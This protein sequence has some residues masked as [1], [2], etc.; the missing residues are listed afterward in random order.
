MKKIQYWFSFFNASNFY[1]MKKSL[2]LTITLL[3]CSALLSAQQLASIKEFSK[4][5]K[6]YPFTDPNP[7]PTKSSIYP[8]FRFDGFTD[9]P[10]EQKWKVVEME[11]QFIK[12]VIL[13]EVGGK[14]WG[15]WEKSTG[16]PFLYSNEVIK[17]RD[18]AMRGPYTS[19][20]IELNYGIFGHTPNCATPV[21]YKTEKKSDGS[22]S[23]YIGTFDKLTQTY[24]TIEVNLPADKAY[25]TTRSTWH[26]GNPL[27]QP[28]YHWMNAA[29]PATGGL[30]F[31][32]PGLSHIGHYG[33]YSTWKTNPDN[34]KD[35]SFY[36][37]NDFGTYKSYHVLGRYTDF[38]GTFY[39]TKNFGM[40]HYAL[41]DEKP[42]K[43]IWIWGLSRQGMIWEKLLTD[44]DGQYVEVQSGRLFNQAAPRSE[45]TPFKN[46]GFAPYSTDEWTEYWFP[47]KGT[48]GMVKA[49]PYGSLN[50][51]AEGGFLKW[52]F[53]PLQDF[54]ETIVVTDGVKIISDK[55]VLFKTL[56]PYRDS[57]KWSGDIK[58]ISLTMGEKMLYRADP[59]TE[60][61][62]RPLDLPSDFKWDTPHALYI[63]G[64]DAAQS[65]RY[66]KAENKFVECLQKD[67]YYSPALAEMAFLQL[68]KMDYGSARKSALKALSI[69]TYDP[70]A[71][72]AL[73]L[74]SVATQSITD[75]KDAFGIASAS[76]QF[77]SA[78]HTELAKLYCRE[79]QL[80]L[81][82]AYAQKAIDA[83]PKNLE[84]LQVMAII[85]RQQGQKE[86]A[87][88][89]LDRI[90]QI[91]PLSHF[92]DSE[93]FISNTLAAADFVGAIQQEMKEEI[94]LDLANTYQNVNRPADALAV[95]KQAPQ[96]AEVLYWQAYLLSEL[97]DS[98]SSEMLSKADLENPLFVF[99]YRTL[100]GKVFDWA[101]QH[102]PSWKP[103]YFLGL[104]HWN[105]GNLHIAKKLFQ[106][107][108]NPIFAPFHAAKAA[109]IKDEA[110]QVLIQ[111]VP[112]DKS[113]SE[114]REQLTK[115]Y[116]SIGEAERSL[117]QAVQLDKDEWLYRKLLTSH[118]VSI[119]ESKRALATVLDYH[120]RFP[121]NDYAA[122]LTA[123]CQMLNGQYQ[124]S[125][126][127]LV[128][129]NFLPNEGAREGRQLYNE[130]LLMMAFDNLKKAKYL[131][132]LKNIEKAREWPENLGVGKPYDS[133]LDERFENF[134]QA[135]CLEKMK[136][137]TE[138]DK[139]YYSLSTEKTDMKTVGLLINALS[140]KKQGT[141]EKGLTLLQQWK[142]QASD[143]ALPD[144]CIEN[145]TGKGKASE[146]PTVNDQTRLLKE[147]LE[148]LK[149]E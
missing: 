56:Q 75:A 117:V 84:A 141:P 67:P 29:M 125:H 2:F 16:Q 55:K 31:I 85:Y 100:A 108:G 147:L 13:P 59:S 145:F 91:N 122:F 19:G 28:Y 87:V 94:F 33:Q 37:Q 124:E 78:A 81:A 44:A 58:K 42:G 39:H 30:E 118:Y 82:V 24:W 142:D 97:H 106:Q 69:D 32:Y 137:K 128:S 134:L 15:A 76:V 50:L 4:T 68:R 52:Y 43:K 114:L 83:N 126:N 135:V 7:V 89:V 105:S 17:F 113:K 61:L 102:S 36:E 74:A 112:L 65:K 62:A 140:L 38:Y 98:S 9:R 116:L 144:W 27:G 86:K 18:V 26:N 99:P 10:V 149:G 25:F 92:V 51:K 12:L 93:K 133:E 110:E 73:G 96:Q 1:F 139:I 138:A 54:D 72:F 71:N 107:C 80:G 21:D 123:K 88:Q 49:N 109:L 23:C 14:V 131:D 79:A 64:K 120:K 129:R 90:A 63:L 148:F 57:L 121:Q 47:A 35:I 136:K 132:A 66:E 45:L 6:T 115:Y 34:G 53:S 20:G 60:D 104:I 3:S 95:L 130:V 41:Y 103:K 101:T 22:V 48:F 40:G 119:N 8:Y 146:P 70:A 111:T 46:R 143:K 5:F 11:N 127:L 77:R